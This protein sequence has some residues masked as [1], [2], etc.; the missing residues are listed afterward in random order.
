MKKLIFL[1][2]ILLVAF[3]LASC[4]TSDFE[5]ENIKLNGKN[6]LKLGF[7]DQNGLPIQNLE[8]EI[9][10]ALTSDQE[11]TIKVK[12][13]Q[14]GQIHIKKIPENMGYG[15]FIREPELKVSVQ[16][17]YTGDGPY[18]DCYA[19]AIN[20]GKPVLKKETTTDEEGK[21]SLEDISGGEE[22]GLFLDTV[23]HVMGLS[24]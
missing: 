17:Q 21:A 7:T 14:K 2:M 11:G 9:I 18:F 23:F 24:Y 15:I 1:T 5:L 3:F 20:N 22:Y 6:W 10:V 16:V 13:D 12:S 4:A 8:C 19:Y